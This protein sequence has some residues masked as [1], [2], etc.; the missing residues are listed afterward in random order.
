MPKVELHVHLEGSIRPATLLELAARNRVALPAEDE[1]GIRAWY[2]F[3]DFDH[4]IEIYLAVSRCIRT[5]ADLELIT[6]RF[7][8][9]QASQRVLYSEV[10]LTAYTHHRNSGMEFADQLAAINRARAWASAELGVEMRLTLDYPRQLDARGFESV[11]DWAIEGRHDGVAAIGLGGPEVGHPP[12]AFAQGFA[13]ARAAGIPSAPHAGETEGPPSIWGAL[14]SLAADR[15]GHGVRCLEDPGLVDELRARRIPLEVCPTSNV[16]LGVVPSLADHPLPRLRAE[17]LVVTV[18]SD[19]PPMF[20]TTLTR[21]YE[22]TASAFGWDARDLRALVRAAAAAAFLP[23]EER[24]RL[25]N[26]LEASF[27]RVEEA[28]PELAGGARGP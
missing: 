13:R 11:V 28:G 4:F 19:D 16:R 23:D 25:G 8:E 18:N 14:R 2:S 15:L 1:E 22:R 3:R 21:E 27:R 10:T 6:R 20:G 12:D 9:G 26:R 17:G 5:P 24:V 7:L